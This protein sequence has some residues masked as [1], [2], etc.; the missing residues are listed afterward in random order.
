M[1]PST[2]FETIANQ[3]MDAVAIQAL[4]RRPLLYADLCEQIKETIRSLNEIGIGRNDRVAVVLPNGSEMA[5]VCLAVASCSTCAPLNPEYKQQEFEYF[6]PAVHAK[7]LL[8]QADLASSARDVAKRLGIPI[9]ELRPRADLEA[10]RFELAR[11]P[12]IRARVEPSLAGLAQPGDAAL[13]LHTSGTTS[14]PKIVVLTQANL[15]A[16]AANLSASLALAPNDRALNMMPLFHI[17]GLVD[18]LLAPLSVGASAI[19]TQTFSVP[20]FVDCL[21]A[22][23]PTV[24]QGVPTM[25]KEILATGEGTRRA[26]RA[27]SLRLVRSVSAALPAPVLAAF[28][29]EYGVPIVEIYGMTEAS[30]LIASNP[31]PPGLRKEGSVGVAAG[32]E[33]RVLGETLE[34][35][36]AFEQGEVAIRGDSVISEYES[37]TEVNVDSFVGSWL[38][39][40]DQGYLD[41]DGYLFLTGRLKEIINRGGE[42]ISPREVDA[43]LD[44]HPAVAEAATFA[45]PHD[46]LGEDVAVAIVLKPGSA[47]SKQEVI[48]FLR[49]RLAYFKVPRV[50]HFCD[51]I[52]KTPGGKLQRTRLAERLNLADADP[53]VVERPYAPPESPVAKTLCRMWEGVLEVERIGIHDDFFDLGGVP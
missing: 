18:L 47:F 11:E 1:S 26:V 30:G 21:Q 34:P 46:A 7:L 33:I 9:L 50:V 28:E 41:E 31:I 10:G 8:V 16:S 32:P 36:A 43:L 4:G 45:I 3:S 5:A 38:R 44:S 40:G 13:V 53:S 25:L 42:K 20:G 51:E 2:V 17:G 39:T 24:Y 12:K 15:M 52:P 23:D 37:P 14:R 6:L 27:S 19:C 22:F 35:V 48:D 49:P 29:R